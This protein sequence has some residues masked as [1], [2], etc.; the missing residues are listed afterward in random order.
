MKPAKATA[1]RS[2][3][4]RDSGQTKRKRSLLFLARPFRRKRRVRGFACTA[5]FPRLVRCYCCAWGERERVASR[6][7]CRG[8]GNVP[9]YRIARCQKAYIGMKGSAWKRHGNFLSVEKLAANVSSVLDRK[10]SAGHQR[11]VYSRRLNESSLYI[12]FGKYICQS[13]STD[14]EIIACLEKSGSRE[15]FEHFDGSAVPR[16]VCAI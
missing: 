1:E 6:G 13:C 8:R 12:F 11:L 3:S 2:S 7:S 4:T 10:K 14:R 9:N 5:K 16:R 15:H